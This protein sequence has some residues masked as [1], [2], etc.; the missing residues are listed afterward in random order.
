[1][2]KKIVYWRPEVG[3]ISTD[4]VAIS[5][6]LGIIDLFEGGN[7]YY[8][9]YHSLQDHEANIKLIERAGELRERLSPSV[10]VFFY[11][12]IPN[13]ASCLPENYPLWLPE[14]PTSTFKELEHR[15][16]S[17]EG[18]LFCNWMRSENIE[19]RRKLWFETD[20]HWSVFGARQ[21]A[22]ELLNKIKAPI[23][24]VKNTE[25]VS[26]WGGDL[27]GRW[28][29]ERFATEEKHRAFGFDAGREVVFDNGLGLEH[30]A[31][32]GRFLQW[33]NLLAT[34]NMTILIVG[35][36]F[37][38]TGISPEHMTYWLSMVFKNT[39]FLHSSVV[40][41][42]VIERLRPD[43]VIYQ[44]NERFL[45]FPVQKEVS[46]ESLIQCFSDRISGIEK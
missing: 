12:V 9:A 22:I 25:V 30:S 1:M 35:D 23:P 29:A 8:Q 36:S 33:N 27:S 24:E 20:S 2:D 32:T 17:I 28:G 44:T 16:S 11:L 34:V 41:S 13:K 18:N 42:D 40:P 21:A 14:C 19:N 26:S 6:N 38:G 37:S 46:I 31:N 5:G 3:A 7:F 15:L 39:Y 43:V 10:Q 45:R 4:R